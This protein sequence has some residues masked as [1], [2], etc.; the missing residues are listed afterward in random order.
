MKYLLALAFLVASPAAAEVV[1]ADAHDFDVRHSV[2]LKGPAASAWSYF[3]QIGKW[4]SADHSYSG[5]A[6][7]LSLSPEPGGCFCE[8]VGASGGVEHLQVIVA[9]PPKRLV[10]T[11]ALGPLLYEGVSG[12]MDVRFDEAD[13]A[14]NVSIDYRASGFVRGTGPELAKAVDSVLGEQVASY[15]RFAA[16]D[17]PK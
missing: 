7:N 6:S 16:G 10:M 8:R 17:V 3:V 9:L 2:R 11:G 1:S 4:W 15:A 13:G 12:V 5:N 14:T